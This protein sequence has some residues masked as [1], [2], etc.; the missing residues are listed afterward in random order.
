MSLEYLN[1]ISI[2]SSSSWNVGYMIYDVLYWN[3]VIPMQSCLASFLFSKMCSLYAFNT[4]RSLTLSKRIL[5]V[6]RA[7]PGAG[8]ELKY[9][10]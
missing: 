4:K 7:V 2:S 8:W 1:M 9:H 3:E 6:V 5:T 10:S